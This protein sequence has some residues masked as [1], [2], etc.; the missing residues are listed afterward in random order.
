MISG[1]ER[2]VRLVE[3]YE[4]SFEDVDDDAFEKQ[5]LLERQLLLHPV[6]SVGDV[7]AKL[8]YLA[9]VMGDGERSDGADV[10]A[11]KDAAQWMDSRYGS[12]D[13]EQLDQSRRSQD[14][15][16]SAS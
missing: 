1:L 6:Q 7:V 12:G 13:T 11:L 5:D 4:Q 14:L 3:E 15:G 8:N 16:R 10:I 2:L 9:R